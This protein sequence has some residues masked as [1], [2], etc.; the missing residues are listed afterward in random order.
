MRE[1]DIFSWFMLANW[2]TSTYLR[3]GWSGMTGLVVQMPLAGLSI[4]RRAWHCGPWL[5]DPAL[6]AL[7]RSQQYR[8]R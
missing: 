4:L 8:F 3:H 7:P 2:K 6:A 5:P 1:P